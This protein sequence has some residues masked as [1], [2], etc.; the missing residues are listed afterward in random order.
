MVQAPTPAIVDPD[1]SVQPA[2]KPQLRITRR[3]AVES[4]YEQEVVVRHYASKPA[5]TKPVQSQSGVRRYSD[6]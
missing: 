3:P 2:P 4:E 6:D 1:I 5:P